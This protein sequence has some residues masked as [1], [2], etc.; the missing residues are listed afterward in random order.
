MPSKFHINLSVFFYIN[1]LTFLL[2]FSSGK[3]REL[4]RKR[5]KYSSRFVF[6]QWEKMSAVVETWMG[7]LTKLREKVRARK[8]VSSRAQK[9]RAAVC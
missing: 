4:K 7:E 5:A 6:L 9:K 1:P 3:E 8:Q 2:I